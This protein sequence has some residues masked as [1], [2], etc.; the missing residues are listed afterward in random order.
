MKFKTL[1]LIVP[2]AFALSACGKSSTDATTTNSASTS[3]PSTNGS[4]NTTPAPPTGATSGSLVPLPAGASSGSTA[5]TSSNGCP[6]Y[7]QRNFYSYYRTGTGT[8]MV[9]TDSNDIIADTKL[10]VSI[11]P[12]SAGSTAGT[13]GTQAY[14]QMAATVT[15]VRNGTEVA[16]VDIPV[17]N[18]AATGYSSGVAV[19][20]L[21]DPAI[22]DFSSFLSGQGHY[23]IKV[24][25]VRT[26]YKCNTF[27]TA[28]YYGCSP[29]YCG[30]YGYSWNWDIHTNYYSCCPGGIDIL[31]QCQ[32]QQC[33][34][35]TSTSNGA[36]SLTVKVETDI[37][38]CITG[39]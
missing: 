39:Y 26:D 11:Q 14:T 21:S 24:S 7:P 30:Y 10:R 25:N 16:S 17:Q 35:G 2:V 34:V 31:N 23:S 8:G 38:S 4:T 12:G 5:S 19:N 18:N 28:S 37:T 32:R 27:C 20:H 33:G 22:A 1:L 15:L 36:W 9:Y 29:S 6:V 13:G 3:A